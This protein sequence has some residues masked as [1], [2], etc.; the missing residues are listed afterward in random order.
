M[1]TKQTICHQCRLVACKTHQTQLLVMNPVQIVMSQDVLY[2]YAYPM[3][4]DV[5]QTRAL[6]ISMTSGI[7]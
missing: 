6:S 2:C 5:F 7:P 4:I 1:Y 3:K